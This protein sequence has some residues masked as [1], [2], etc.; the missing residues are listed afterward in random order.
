MN[1][2]FFFSSRRRHTRFKC[3]WSSDVCS[4][5]LHPVEIAEHLWPEKIFERRDGKVERGEDNAVAHY[6]LEG[7]GAVFLQLELRVHAPF[8]LV[9]TPERYGD[10]HARGVVG[11]LMIG[12]DEPLGVAAGVAT[13]DD[14]AV[15]A[16]IGEHVDAA[17]A[18]ARHH[19]R[20]VADI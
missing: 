12:A 13:E 10:Q 20:L 18:V 5:D 14:S 4:S 15:R 3:D 8:A 9:A 7:R 17:V 6:D 19:H 2:F 11:P 16:V 1:F